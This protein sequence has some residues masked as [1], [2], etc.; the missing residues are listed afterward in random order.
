MDPEKRK[1]ILQHARTLAESYAFLDTRHSTQRRQ[2]RNIPISEIRRAIL[3]GTREPDRDRFSEDHKQWSY[4]IRG[5][6]IDNNAIRVVVGFVP[7]P[8]HNEI[9]AIVTAYEV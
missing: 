8:A 5:L 7:G 4:S 1:N 2:E 9:L 6:D 3:N